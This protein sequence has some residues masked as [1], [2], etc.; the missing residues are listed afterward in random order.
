MAKIDLQLH[1]PLLKVSINPFTTL[2]ILFFHQLYFDSENPSPVDAG[3]EFSYHIGL[4]NDV[5]IV[6]ILC[7]LLATVPDYF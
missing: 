2:H 6:F 4:H 3:D 5:S 1:H 7:S